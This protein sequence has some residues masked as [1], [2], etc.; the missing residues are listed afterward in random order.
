MMRIFKMRRLF[1]LAI[2]LILFI[3]PMNSALAASQIISKEVS[4]TGHSK[5]LAIINGLIEAIRQVHGLEVDSLKEFKTKFEENYQDRNGKGNNNTSSSSSHRQRILSRAK[6]YIKSY[7]VLHAERLENGRGWEVLLLV[8]LVKYKPTG[9]NRDNSRMRTMAI[10]PFRV[11]ASSYMSSGR[12]MSAMEVSRQFTQRLISE[13]TQARKFRVL[14]REYTAEIINEKNILRSGEVPIT[15]MVR[16]GQKLGADYMVVGNIAEYSITEQNKQY[17]GVM[18]KQ[19]DANLVVDYRV[20]EVAPQEVRWSNTLDLFYDNGR[21]RNM[22][23]RGNSSQVH[24]AIFSHA[25]ASIVSEILDVIY[26]IKVMSASSPESVYVNQGGI[27]VKQGELFEIF[28]PGQK[29]IDPDTGLKI[30]V[31]GLKT[32]TIKIESV[33]PTYSVG[34][35]VEGSFAKIKKRAICRRKSPDS[36]EINQNIRP[37]TAGSSDKPV[38][39]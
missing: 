25:G 19:R 30:R 6:G 37:M 20:I 18:T 29:F 24:H 1:N 38:D 36:R 26:P 14:D 39:W 12:K 31:D 34:Q 33:L 32:A 7:D 17:S 9:V 23:A 35:V 4:G 11:Q 3:L 13:M 10:M 5:E 8:D 22:G 2:I 21:L 15:E 16:L 28:T 27:R